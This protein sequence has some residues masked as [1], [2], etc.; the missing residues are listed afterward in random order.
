MSWYPRKAAKPAARIV[1]RGLLSSGAAARAAVNMPAVAGCRQRWG[2]EEVINPLHEAD[3][4]FEKRPQEHM[5]IPARL[6]THPMDAP[7]KGAEAWGPAAAARPSQP[8]ASLNHIAEPHCCA[9][10]QG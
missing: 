7:C 10:V 6:Q 4:G 2:K 5:S 1:G 8:A 9:D 3:D